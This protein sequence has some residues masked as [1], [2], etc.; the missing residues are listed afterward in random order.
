M[1]L[2]RCVRLTCSEIIV[3]VLAFG[4]I[5]VSILGNLWTPPVGRPFV[6]KVC[7]SLPDCCRWN[8][9]PQLYTK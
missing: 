2:C 1:R 5:I 6:Q 7:S 3:Q 8:A 4:M 9:S